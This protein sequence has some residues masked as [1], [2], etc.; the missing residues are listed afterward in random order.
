MIFDLLIPPQSPRGRGQNVFAVA[1]PIHVS[2]SHT[3]FGWISFYGLGGDSITDGRTEEITIT[4]S[5]FLKKHES[6]FFKKKRGDND[7]L[8]KVF[9]VFSK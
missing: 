7:L 3:K 1:C 4:H 2:S 8:Q 9:H 5:L 6:F